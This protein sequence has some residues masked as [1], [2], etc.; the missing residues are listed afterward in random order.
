MHVVITCIVGIV[1]LYIFCIFYKEMTHG[2]AALFHA[3]MG[4]LYG[5]ATFCE[6]CSALNKV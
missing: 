5:A 6:V 2:K 4:D 1:H 3:M